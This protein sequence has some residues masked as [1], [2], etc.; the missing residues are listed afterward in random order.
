MG[1]HNEHHFIPKFLLREWE[2][3]ADE[4]LSA[5]RWVRGQISENRYKAKSVAKERHLYAMRRSSTEP[6]QQ[7]E[8]EFMTKHVDDPASLVHKQILA[9]GLDGLTQDQAY[10]WTRFLVSLAYRGP[11]AVEHVRESGIDAL[12]LQVSSI[13][14]NQ[15]ETP[16]EAEKTFRE[17]VERRDPALL[18]FGTYALPNLIQTSALNK[19]IFESKWMTRR[20]TTST[21]RFLIGDRPLTLFHIAGS[22]LLFLPLAPGLALLAFNSSAVEQWLRK[23][24]ERDFLHQMNRVMVEQASV[25]VWGTNTEHQRLLVS[26]LH[27][28]PAERGLGFGPRPSRAQ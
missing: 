3:G 2:G 21:R 5:M 22:F 28:T 17:H 1:T 8:R 6:N 13:F 24:S 20:L 25:Y 27:K 12:G 26:R 9:N 11:G 7:L 10:T 4:K 18:D 14:D 16:S 23:V 15:L 19:I